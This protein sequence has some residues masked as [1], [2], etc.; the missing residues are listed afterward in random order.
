MTL[1]MRKKGTWGLYSWAD[2]FL[3]SAKGELPLDSEARRN[4]EAVISRLMKEERWEEAERILDL[5]VG[6]PY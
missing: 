1:I 5:Y 4:P 3:A 6:L 2:G